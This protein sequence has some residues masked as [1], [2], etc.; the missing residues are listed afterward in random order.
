MNVFSSIDEYTGPLRPNQE[1]PAD[2]AQV[3]LARLSGPITPG[4]DRGGDS[5]TYGGAPSVILQSAT[6]CL[7][8]LVPVLFLVRDSIGPQK[9][10]AN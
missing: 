4:V 3:L 8:V 5:D 7:P 1:R 6:S 10:V 2:A 9:L